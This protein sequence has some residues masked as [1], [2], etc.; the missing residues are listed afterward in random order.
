VAA[1]TRDGKEFLVTLEADYHDLPSTPAR[2]LKVWEW[3]GFGF[4]L[5]AA[6]AGR[7]TQLSIGRQ[8]VGPDFILAP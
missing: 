1:L 5:V 2:Q 8:T 4:S 3:N 6:S 7:F